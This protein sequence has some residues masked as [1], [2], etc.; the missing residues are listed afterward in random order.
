M[1]SSHSGLSLIASYLES[2]KNKY[3]LNK[4]LLLNNDEDNDEYHFALVEIE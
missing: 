2:I 1:E 4:T 3:G